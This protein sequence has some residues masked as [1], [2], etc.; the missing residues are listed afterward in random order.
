MS[1][2][3][4]V[5]QV[6]GI[7]LDTFTVTSTP[8]KNG[9]SFTSQE[10]DMTMHTFEVMLEKR[11]EFLLKVTSSS[12]RETRQCNVLESKFMQ[13]ESGISDLH[14]EMFVLLYCF[15]LQTRPPFHHLMFLCFL[16]I[17]L[18]FI[19]MRVSFPTL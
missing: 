8:Q 13:Q 10:L 9:L 14:L 1:L 19:G 17:Y 12:R 2:Y 11:K 16:A 4:Q 6:F 15:V 7:K 5:Y 18:L 3:A